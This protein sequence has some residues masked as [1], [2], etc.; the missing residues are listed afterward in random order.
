MLM[1]KFFVWH[2]FFH[3]FAYPTNCF[4]TSVCTREN[5]VPVHD[6]PDFSK[7][8]LKFNSRMDI[9]E[10][11]LKYCFANL[12]LNECLINMNP[13]Y[14]CKKLQS[15]FK[16]SALGLVV[17]GNFSFF[18]LATLL[19]EI[20]HQAIRNGIPNLPKCR[21][22][23]LLVDDEKTMISIFISIFLVARLRDSGIDF[24]RIWKS[25]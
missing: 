16:H 8:H 2:K 25:K 1:I 4:C 23:C 10:H 3:V 11:F 15:E 14:I 19:F 17:N 9:Y 6:C 22:G 12:C 24:Q 5:T 13:C 20:L 7:I 21:F 18:V